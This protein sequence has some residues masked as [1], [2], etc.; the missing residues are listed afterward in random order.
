ML[1]LRKICNKFF[2]VFVAEPYEVAL[3]FAI[4]LCLALGDIFVASLIF[5]P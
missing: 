3:K 1:P 4:D 2:I 5:K